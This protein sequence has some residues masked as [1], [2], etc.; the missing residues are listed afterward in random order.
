MPRR[1]YKE[2]WNEVYYDYL[3]AGYSDLGAQIKAD[4]AV[5]LHRESQLDR[6]DDER[7]ERKLRGKT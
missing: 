6:A 3:E 1:T 4:F 7:H 2:V 5:Q